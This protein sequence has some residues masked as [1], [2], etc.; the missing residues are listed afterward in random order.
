MLNYIILNSYVEFVGRFSFA[1]ARSQ[2]SRNKKA[3]TVR[4]FKW[5]V[6]VRSMDLVGFIQSIQVVFVSVVWTSS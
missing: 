3:A 5:V 1:Q 4:V 2:P 6:G